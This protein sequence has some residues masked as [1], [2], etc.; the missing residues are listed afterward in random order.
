[1]NQWISVKD[2]LPDLYDLV[3]WK[4]KSPHTRV[5]GSYY[6]GW[7]TEEENHPF[8]FIDGDRD[9]NGYSKDHPPDYWMPLPEPPE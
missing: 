4:E 6:I 2:E 7:L 9:V 1:M 8:K 3:W 5:H